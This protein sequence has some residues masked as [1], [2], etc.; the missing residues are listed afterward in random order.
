MRT[1]TI[2]VTIGRDSITVQPD[3]LI[4]TTDDEVQ[5][6]G[7]DAKKFSIEF[8]GNGPFASPKLA[9]AAAISRQRPRMLGR[10]KYSVISDENPNLILD[11]GIIIDPP[12]TPGP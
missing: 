3:P 8:D 6:S 2:S 5:W 11:P 7:K 10:F 1:H 4:M 12:P 9:H